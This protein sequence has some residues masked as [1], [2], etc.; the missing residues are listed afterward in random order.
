MNFCSSVKK[1]LS[2]E[3]HYFSHFYKI[4]KKFKYVHIILNFSQ[5]KVQY[6]YKK[7]IF[8]QFCI[9]IQKEQ[10]CVE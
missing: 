6:Y 3:K 8:T 1:L 5:I 4:I 2:N 7:M 9:T 10:K